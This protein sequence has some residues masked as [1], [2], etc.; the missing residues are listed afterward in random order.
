MSP[1]QIKIDLR[2]FSV[3]ELVVLIGICVVAI[4]VTMTCIVGLWRLMRLEVVEHVYR[5]LD[6]IL[7]LIAGML[8]GSALSKRP[9]QP[10]P[11]EKE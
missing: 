2:R 5:L 11:N 9:N 1:I 6:Q 4:V 3:T 7:A 10:A 8:G